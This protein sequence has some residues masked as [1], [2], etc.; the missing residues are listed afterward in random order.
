MFDG[1]VS[2]QRSDTLEGRLVNS[3]VYQKSWLNDQDLMS[4]IYVYGIAN[5]YSEFLNGTKVA[6][7]GVCFTNKRETLW[8]S[9]GLA[10]H[11]I[12]VFTCTQSMVK[13]L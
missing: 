10:V 6:V 1:H 13:A 8:A 3:A 9:L 11:T 7:S 5:F 4:R 2:N 12:G